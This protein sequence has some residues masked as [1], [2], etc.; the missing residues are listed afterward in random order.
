MDDSINAFIG[1]SMARTARTYFGGNN[2]N[3]TTKI[4]A[5]AKFDSDEFAF[6]TKNLKIQ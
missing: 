6:F 4:I 5:V 3:T 2:R 1:S